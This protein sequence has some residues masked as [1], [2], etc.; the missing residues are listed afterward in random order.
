[1][2]AITTF[3]PE[4]LRLQLPRLVYGGCFLAGGAIRD[5]LVGEEPSDFDNLGSQQ[6]PIHLG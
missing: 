2:A 5:S 1:M 4:L 6:T 3:A